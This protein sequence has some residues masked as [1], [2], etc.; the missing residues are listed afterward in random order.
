[1]Y[2]HR[3]TLIAVLSLA[4]VALFANR[5]VSQNP[6]ADEKKAEAP[7]ANQIEMP[8]PEAMAKAMKVT[9]PGPA[10]EYFKKIVGKWDVVMKVSM[11]GPGSPPIETTGESEFRL[12][13]G[14][15]FVLEEVRG[16]MMGMPFDG[17]GITGYDNDKNLYV[18]TWVDNMNTHMLHMS[19]SRDHATGKTLTMYGTMS[20]PMLDVSD[21]MVKYVTRWTGDD[22]FVLEVYDLHVSDDYKVVEIEYKRQ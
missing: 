12:I 21:R 8:S 7:P 11:G 10:H 15:R 17:M 13:M 4:A 14:G 20:E 2:V 3:T 22:S 9:R 1:M 6:P 18:S 16:S 19:G 5:A